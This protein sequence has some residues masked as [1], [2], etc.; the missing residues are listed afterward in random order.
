M[1]YFGV[2]VSY[3]KKRY[4]VAH[5]KNFLSKGSLSEMRRMAGNMNA[6][7]RGGLSVIASPNTRPVR[8][9]VGKSYNYII[10]RTTGCITGRTRF[11][12]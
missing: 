11:R 3:R 12:Q 7:A 8:L 2:S 5:S 10:F 9:E 6:A 1:A 4:V